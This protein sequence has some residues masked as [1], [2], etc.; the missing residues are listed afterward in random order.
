MAEF[1]V[2]NLEALEYTD[3]VNYK[4][5]YVYA[6]AIRK[7]ENEIEVYVPDIN[8]DNIND[9]IEGIYAI[10]KDGIET[11]YIHNFIVKITWGGDLYAQ[12]SIV[13]YWYNLFMWNMVLKN[14][15]DIRPKHLFWQ[16]ELKKKDIK[17]FVDRFV[18]TR[19][20]KIAKGNDF[21]NDNLCDG[22]WNWSNIETFSGYL[23]NTINNEDDIDMMNMIPEY[24]NLMH[25]SLADVPF[26]Q[27]KNVGMDLTHKAIDYI[28]DSEQYLGY[29]HGLANSFRASEA[30]SDRQFK[31]VYVNI[32]TKSNGSGSVYPINIDKSF[33]MG[34]VNDPESYFVESSTARAAQIMSKTNVGDSG[35]YARILGLNNTDT[36][37]NLDPDYMCASRN[38]IKYEIKTMKHLD[39]IKNRYYRFNPRGMEYLIDDKDESLVGKTIYLRSPMTCSSHAH[40]HGICKRCYGDLYYTNIDINVGKFAA[41]EL[42]SQLTQR[43]LS[44]KHLLETMIRAMKWNSEFNDWFELD[45]NTIR[46]ADLSDIDNLRKYYLVVDPEDIFLVSEEED[47]VTMLDEDGNEINIEA[48][49][50]ARYNEYITH[51]NIKTPD[52]N[53]IWFGTED[54]DS[55]Y[56]SPALNNIIR[57]KAV[58]GEGQV[59]LIPLANLV[60]EDLFYV[61]INNDEISKTM[62]DII[63]V[64]NKAS[65]TEQMTKDE[66]MQAM[67]DLVVSG[68]L[69]VD[70]I[71]LEVILSN[72]IV[73][74][75]DIL[76]KPDWDVEN[77]PYRMFTLDHAL[78]NNP[79]VIVSLLYK[80]LH[81]VLYNPLTFTK[82]APSFFDMFFMVQPQNYMNEDLLATEVNI[83]DPEK[84][85][86]MVRYVN[87]D[88]EES[89]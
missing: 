30:V 81:R 57:H 59:V 19:E 14:G 83:Q 53:M 54:Q 55:M 31:E 78:S 84:G 13:D 39:M 17:D 79:S 40:G 66:A 4:N 44:S 77:I 27:V 75:K 47:A 71:H 21:L 43:L 86:E 1:T 3:L 16:R 32:G 5:Y 50:S 62:N 8:T 80:D 63:N 7:W 41:E 56:I 6:D 58:A 23:A 34:G 10:L 65:I 67:V 89:N 64:T 24:Y 12:L 28:K 25:A 73:N 72:Q 49:D 38:F 18:L 36:I 82:N 45:I 85:L 42:S 60:D 70:A 22:L 9:H 37:L 68:H 26:D 69:N 2:P 11:D 35:D 46:L 33:K 52:G 51:F 61:K 29:E 88:E 15:E 87:K 76:K 74:P 20:Q 48:E